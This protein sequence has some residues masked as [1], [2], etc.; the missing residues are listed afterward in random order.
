MVFAQIKDGL[1]KNTIVLS[2]EDI[3]L[4]GCDPIT[5]IPYDLI[6]RIDL[7]YPQPG[8]GWVFDGIQFS[9]SGDDT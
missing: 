9:V 4:F 1:I 6:L 3:S 5:G 8:I 7:I 2:N